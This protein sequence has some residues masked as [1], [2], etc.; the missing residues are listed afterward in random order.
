MMKQTFT[1]LAAA[2]LLNVGASAQIPT[3]VLV[4]ESTNASCGPCASQNPAF[5]ALLDAN[6]DKAIVLKYQW[7]FPGFDPMHNDNVEDALN[8]TAYY[9]I[10]GVPTAAIAGELGDNDYCDGC[11]DWNITSSGGYEGGPY[12][13]NQAVL[14]YAHSIEAP[15][16]M[17]IS[18]E[19]MNGVLHVTGDITAAMAMSGNLKLRIALAEEK[20]TFASAPGSNGETEFNHVMKAFVGGNGGIELPDMAMGDVYTIDETL[21]IA[22][23]NVYDFSE[24]EVIAFVQN[25]TD[26]HVFQAAKDNTVEII[27]EYTNSASAAGITDIPSSLCVGPQDYSPTFILSNQGNTEL[28]S[29]TITYNINGGADQTY[30][31][32]GSLP[33]LSSE[34]VV[35]DAYSFDAGLSNTIT[36]TVS[37]PN[38]VADEDVTDNN[39][40]TTELLAPFAGPTVNIEILSDNYGA[41]TTWEL[42]DAGGVAVL[43]GGPLTNNTTYN[44]SYSAP[45]GE[46]GCYEFVI[47]D[48]YGDGICCTY[49]EGYFRLS[50]ESGD[51]IL[52]GGEFTDDT[53]ES[54][55]MVSSVGVDEDALASAIAIGP[56]PVNDILNVKINLDSQEAVSIEMMNAVGQKVYTEYLGSISNSSVTAIDVKGLEAGIYYVTV[57]AGDAATTSKITVLK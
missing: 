6:E 22:G 30:N 21:S 33:L 47:F 17:T 26:K 50:D 44:E 32:T 23:I 4:E 14:D 28:T 38:G 55:S 16:S 43:S 12:G 25:D 35:L 1:I 31:W 34:N 20:I 9:G 5:D 54:V 37:M 24:L 29:A 19:L 39:T 8:R 53:S 51:I 11:G 13:H 36:A 52:E 56:N 10:N 57:T 49:G 18:A 2:L 15:I 7:Y 45:F 46:D 42:R 40:A 48:S 27:S 3:M 41:E